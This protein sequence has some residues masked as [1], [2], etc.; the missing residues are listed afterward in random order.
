MSQWTADV[1]LLV[2]WEPDQPSGEYSL[3]P[4]ESR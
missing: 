2:S 3:V 1:L 4:Y